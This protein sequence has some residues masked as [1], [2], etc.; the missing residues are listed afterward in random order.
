M[1]I[2]PFVF[3]HENLLS[4]AHI[5]MK[6]WRRLEED[7]QQDGQGQGQQSRDVEDQRPTGINT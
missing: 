7:L 5:Q 4:D 1:L 3:G 2:L 6:R